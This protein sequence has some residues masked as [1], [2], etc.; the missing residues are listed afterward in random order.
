MKFYT[1]LLSL[2]PFYLQAQL[3]SIPIDFESTSINYTFYDFGGVANSN[4]AN[5]P[6][7]TGNNTSAKVLQLTKTTDAQT[8]AGTAMPL[9]TSID[10]INNGN[11]MRMAVYSPRAN[12]PFLLKIE[13]LDQGNV[14]VSAEVSVS[15]SLVNTWE[16]FSYDMSLDPSFDPTYSYNQ[17]VIFPD[18]GNTG[19]GE[20]FYVDNIEHAS[21]NPEPEECQ[22]IIQVDSYIH[23]TDSTV[24]AGQMLISNSQVTNAADVNYKAGN[25]I[26]LENNF[27]TQAGSRFSSEIEECCTIKTWY[28]DADGD[29]FGNPYISVEACN[30]PPGYVAT[31]R[32]NSGYSTPLS[33]PG[34]TLIWSDEFDGNTLDATTWVHDLGNG[35]PNVCDWGNNEAIWYQTQNATVGDDFLTIEARE[36]QVGNYNYTSSRIKTQGNKSFQYGRVD[37]RAKLPYSQ[38]VWPALWMLGDNITT[39]GWPACGEIDIM[40]LIGGGTGRDDTTHGTCHWDNNGHNYQGG[41]YTLNNGIF[42]NEFHVFSIIWDANQ[43]RWFV[44][45]I[46]FYSLNTTSSAM[47]EFHNPFFF[48]FNVA[49]GG[50]WPGYPDASTVFP[51][52]ME[53]DYIRVFQ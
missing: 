48:I 5:N 23:T 14:V 27:N 35:C 7:L 13:M 51:Q 40:E 46:Q 44:D 38:G 22:D 19:L 42:A 29:G 52:T 50:N 17:L 32:S 53:V 39:V 10:F 9:Q 11:E 41:S 47:T 25:T 12:V 43:I 30:P 37:I 45:D 33:Y 8:W 6:T 18:F 20:T 24:H 31:P 26:C 16:I 1:L 4:V 2:L 3:P 36:E 49:V 28:L 34:Y 21:T 15:T